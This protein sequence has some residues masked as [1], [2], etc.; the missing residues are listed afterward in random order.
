[1]I[2]PFIKMRLKQNV[3]MRSAADP[4]LLKKAANDTIV[5]KGVQK[6]VEGKRLVL[7]AKQIRVGGQIINPLNANVISDIREKFIQNVRARSSF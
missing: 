2:F 4:D 6:S 3:V 1:M 7:R 5:P